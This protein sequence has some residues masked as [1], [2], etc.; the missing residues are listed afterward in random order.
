MEQLIHRD[1]NHPS[2]VMWSVANEPR[3]GLSNADWYFS[4][5]ASYTKQLD[6]SRPITAAIDT[7]RNLDQAAKYM[8]IISFNR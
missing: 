7:N 2:V 4:E 8:D 1:R 3:S 6:L 5:V